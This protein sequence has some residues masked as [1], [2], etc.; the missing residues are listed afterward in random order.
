MQLEAARRTTEMLRERVGALEAERLEAKIGFE[1]I[2]S[3][4]SR[5]AAETER[6]REALAEIARIAGLGA[7]AFADRAEEDE[8][9]ALWPGSQPH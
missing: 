4:A 1:V 9:V 3:T 7:V 8:R 2:L 6:G 5:A